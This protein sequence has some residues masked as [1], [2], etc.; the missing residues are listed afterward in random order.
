[1]LKRIKALNF[2][3]MTFAVLL[4]CHFA[5]G[6]AGSSPSD[7]EAGIWIVPLD[8]GLWKA[9]PHHIR[10]SEVPSRLTGMISHEKTL[11]TS[12]Y[13]SRK[14]GKDL[15]FEVTG[16][17][18]KRR[19]MKWTCEVGDKDLSEFNYFVIRYK[20]TGIRRGHTPY[21]VIS[22]AGSDTSTEKVVYE[23][24]LNCANVIN[25]D[26]WHVVIVKKQLNLK[27]DTIQLE[28]ST[29]GTAGTIVFDYIGFSKQVP[30][31]PQ[32][33]AYKESTKKTTPGH[34]KSIELGKL[35]NDT[36]FATV[37]RVLNEHGTI[38]DGGTP[39]KSEYITVESVPF[40]VQLE[41]KNIVVI[42]E[43]TEVN[44]EK[45]KFLGGEVLSKHFF[46]PS[47]D[48]T[49]EIAVG[50]KV[51]ELFL[52]LVSETPSSIKHHGV[53]ERPLQLN[54][55]EAFAVELVYADGERDFTFPYSL[56]DDGYLIRRMT[57]AY[58]V[59]ADENKNLKSIIFHN[60]HF[61][62]NINIAA[63][64]LNTSGR[65]VLEELVR[66]P[67]LIRVPD[68]PEPLPRSTYMEQKGKVIT[69]GNSFYDLV[70]NCEKGFSLEKITNRWSSG[71]ELALDPSS[72]LEIVLGELALTGF[73]F[74]AESVRV[75]G[76]SAAI[77]LKSTTEVAPLTLNISI[78]VDNTP[79]I[80]INASVVN[81]GD[82]RLSGTI[83]L[84]IIKGLIIEKHDDTWMFF[85]KYRN[86]ISNDYGFHI[87]HNNQCFPMQFYDV[88]NPKVGIGLAV[89][90][91]NIDLSPLEYNMSKTNAGVSFSVQYPAKYYSLDPGRP[92]QLI[93]A[94]LV[95]HAG[96]W[97][98]AMALYHDWVNSWYK[99]QH[100]KNR[101]WYEQFFLLRTEMPSDIVSWKLLKTPGVFDRKKEVFRIDEAMEANKRFYDTL[102]DIVHF[103]TWIYNEEKNDQG[104]G[105]YYYDNV[106]GLS[107]FKN[108]IKK[109][110][111]KYGIPVS[112]Y[113][114]CDRCS[115]K[116][117]TIGREIGEMVA[118]QKKDGTLAQSEDTWYVCLAAK[119][120]QNFYVE[121][122]RRVQ[123]E[124]GADLIYLDLLSAWQLH[125]CFNQ[126]HGHE[127]PFWPNKVSNQMITRLRE[128]LPPNVVFWTEYPFNDINTQYTD[129]N[130][131]YYFLPLYEHFSRPYDV[132]EK[133]GQDFELAMNVYRFVFP[134]IK[135]VC[136]PVHS[137]TLL[138]WS[139]LK[140][141]FF[142]GEAHYDCS[143]FAY[144]SRAREMLNKCLSVKK[145][146]VDCFTSVEPVPLVFTERAY[147]YANKF[148]G[149]GRIAWT[150]YNGRYTTVRGPV[151]AIAH[152]PGA[153]YYDAWNDKELT[154]KIV[155]GKAM[156]RMKLDPQGLG[157][158][159]QTL[160]GN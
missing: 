28:L 27:A 70:I 80:K 94:C 30:A 118:R 149:N 98:Q 130:I 106:G 145:R 12:A 66:E 101:H 31:F 132:L 154:P 143:W 84:P 43:D 99:T 150:I 86:V 125:S 117:S 38:I 68:L 34:F 136:F 3:C 36:Y 61:G 87:A 131:T 42:P 46:P 50:R 48:D 138:N 63:I 20:A 14:H 11:Q 157:C 53:T 116:H 127:V 6:I 33:F 113:T 158:V 2:V 57:G 123:E 22:V 134:K 124:T 129:G 95:P 133:A 8:V 104:W 78:E 156:I 72:G 59:P 7:D 148:P 142:N 76:K 60:R 140:F 69:C 1:M 81:T 23:T 109:I 79:Q 71:T 151:L 115:K 62:I 54:D 4:L 17:V 100:A 65:R 91:H 51:S 85:P 146:Y 102:P 5:V 13:S 40:K 52:L 47:R 93:E 29:D 82:E 128:N 55:I 105:E 26:R 139:N 97:H 144:T 89:I 73:D 75:N 64:T 25:D 18:T 126:E 44:E 67:E 147:V 108:M 16:F 137:E 32:G 159:V 107:T 121:T 119:E 103:S 77:L 45:I 111:K 120:W 112:L 19:T 153:T 37:N 58:A 15:L 141:I 56:A 41:G 90:T 135:Q 21:P 114:L 155:D 9:M 39:F 152:Q 96:D 10:T 88:Y 35:F 92:I 24:L 110:Q 74:T 160:T 83:K 122:V 49:L